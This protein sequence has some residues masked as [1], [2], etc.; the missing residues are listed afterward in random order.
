MLG[1]ESLFT[2]GP[3]CHSWT[4][5]DINAAQLF[6]QT[7]NSAHIPVKYITHLGQGTEVFLDQ[8]QAFALPIRLTYMHMYVHV[9]WAQELESPLWQ[10]PGSTTVRGVPQEGLRHAGDSST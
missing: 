9:R 3:Y 2:P 1:I 7:T 6:E 5:D 8:K 10:L 4:Y